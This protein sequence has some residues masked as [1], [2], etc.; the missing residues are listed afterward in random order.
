W[1]DI[2]NRKSRGIV[3]APVPEAQDI[4]KGLAQ[5]YPVPGDIIAPHIQYFF[6]DDDLRG[7]DLHGY[8]GQKKVYPFIA[9]KDFY[10][11]AVMVVGQYLVVG[12]GQFYDV[13]IPA[14]SVFTGW[15]PGGHPA[16]QMAD[17]TVEH[18][19]LGVDIIIHISPI[20]LGTGLEL[21]ARS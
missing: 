14:R 8:G 21:H 1:E 5:V 19:G 18:I 10:F 17:G 11:P 13:R 3:I 9:G 15:I 20:V 7:D 6:L 16:A 12:V 4:L 2:P